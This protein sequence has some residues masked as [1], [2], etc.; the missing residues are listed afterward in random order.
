MRLSKVGKEIFLVFDV[1]EN[2]LLKN[3][4][5]W[6]LKHINHGMDTG[7]DIN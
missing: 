6:F 5:S 4:S 3:V 2:D 1:I 7:N